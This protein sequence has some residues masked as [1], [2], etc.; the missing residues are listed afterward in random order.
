MTIHVQRLNKL[1]SYGNCWEPQIDLRSK[2]ERREDV[3]AELLMGAEIIQ[4]AR[5]RGFEKV[6]AILTRP[7]LGLLDFTQS[8]LSRS[9]VL[10]ENL[11]MLKIKIYQAPHSL[12]S[13]ERCKVIL[14]ISNR[15]AHLI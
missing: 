2:I 14:L 6:P 10:P 4:T 1:S 13:H 7:Y 9:I 11:R 5:L 3:G 15:C 12:S 8:N